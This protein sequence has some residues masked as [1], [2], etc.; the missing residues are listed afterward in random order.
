MAIPNLIAIFVLS[1]KVKQLTDKYEK[2]Q[3]PFVN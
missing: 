1:K 2:E 3:H